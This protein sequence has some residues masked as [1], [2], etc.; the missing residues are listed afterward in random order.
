MLSSEGEG[1]RDRLHQW[2]T[3]LPGSRL[4]VRYQ[5]RPNDEYGSEFSFQ[6]EP[7]EPKA[8]SLNIDVV[9]GTKQCVGVT[10]G[11]WSSIA[12]QYR[13]KY[14]TRGYATSDFA[15][16]YVE[17]L[18]MS[19]ERVLSICDAVAQ[20]RV[21]LW[22]GLLGNTITCTRGFVELEAGRFRMNGV[23]GPLAMNRLAGLLGLGEV[24]RIRYAAWH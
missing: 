7:T 22:V 20:G 1:L 4:E 13:L 5:E 8:C 18:E 6:L 11:S 15:A 3:S 21:R 9:S 14:S 24:R 12:E 2:T 16:L 10:L 19:V 23:G 17:P